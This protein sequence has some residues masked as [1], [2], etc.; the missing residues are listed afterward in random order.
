MID[1]LNQALR[2]K[3]LTIHSKYLVDEMQ[4]FVYD[5]GNNMNAIDGYHDDAIFSA[6]IAFQ[7]F[8]VLFSGDLDQIYY[9]D[10]MPSSGGY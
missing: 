3:S 2:E 10:F 5:F 4:T 6:S 8:K 1:D 9:S 7:G